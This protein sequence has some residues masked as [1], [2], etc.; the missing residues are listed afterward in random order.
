M[1]IC[2]FIIQCHKTTVF[3]VNYSILPSNCL[4]CTKISYVTIPIGS[5]LAS[6]KSPGKF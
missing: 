4:L 1:T 2:V 5:C 3:F 6:F